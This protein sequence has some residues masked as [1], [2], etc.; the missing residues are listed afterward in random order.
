MNPSKLLKRIKRELGITAFT[1]PFENPDQ[2]FMEII[3]DTTLSTFSECYPY[4]QDVIMDIDNAETLY[5]T[6]QESLFIIPEM[7]LQGREILYIMDIEPYN[8]KFQGSYFPASSIINNSPGIYEDMMMGQ[9]G[10]DL[11]SSITPVFTWEFVRPNKIKTYNLS[12]FSTLMKIKIGFKHYNNLSTIGTGQEESFFQLAKLDIKTF[13]Y[14]NLK[15]FDKIDTVYGTIDL[16]IEDWANA[17]NDRTD[18]ANRMKESSNLANF[19]SLY[20]R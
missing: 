18:M 5:N 13:L 11:I 4:V 10:A 8:N 20:Y 2:E 7:L 6:Y 9:V 15:H 3:Q 19:P 1:L 12:S 17:E 16:H 14:N